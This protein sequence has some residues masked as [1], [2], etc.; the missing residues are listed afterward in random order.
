MT[1]VY[2]SPENEAFEALLKN[3][4]SCEETLDICVFTL[5]DNR[6]T[7]ALLKLKDEG[8]KVRIITDNEK[9]HDKGSDIQ[10]IISKGIAVKAD[11]GEA[12]MHHKFAIIDNTVSVTGSYNWTR[13]ADGVNYENILITDDS[14]VAVAYKREFDKLW[15]K[16]K[17]LV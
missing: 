6:I 15:K 14:D 12:H 2:F 11:L 8:V 1:K 5:S 3:L 7:E 13:S 9:R 16:F 4:S 10:F 17:R